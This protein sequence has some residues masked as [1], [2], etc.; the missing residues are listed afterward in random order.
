[1]WG[2]K[3]LLTHWNKIVLNIKNYLL[4]DINTLNRIESII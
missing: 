4:P 1:M 3:D 2:V